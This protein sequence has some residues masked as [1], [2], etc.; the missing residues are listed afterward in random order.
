MTLKKLQNF[1]KLNYPVCFLDIVLKEI[2]E[3]NNNQVFSWWDYF[4]KVSKNKDNLRNEFEYLKLLENKWKFPKAISY[5]VLKK[6]YILVI[7]KLNWKW[8]HY[9]WWELTNDEKEKIIEDIIIQVKIIHSISSK[10]KHEKSYIKN[11]NLKIDKIANQISNNPFI[12]GKEFEDIC[13]EIDKYSKSFNNVPENLIHNDL[14]YKNMLVYNNKLSWIIDFECWFFGPIQLEFF[15]L[16]HHKISVSNY[17]D[18]TPENYSEIDFLD[19]LINSIKLNYKEL[20]DKITPEQFYVYNLNS[21]LNQLSRHKESWYEHKDTQEF[22]RNFC[23]LWKV[24]EF[25]NLL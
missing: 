14:W 18:K 25:L 11:L 12:E 23:D 1:L 21:Y 10:L 15:R 19:R 6:N 16:L 20:L 4:I 24:K 8:L 7:S 5:N 9:I 13:K 2:H 22:K 17:E 3:S